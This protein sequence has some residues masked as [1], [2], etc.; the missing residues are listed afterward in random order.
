MASGGIEPL[1]WKIGMHGMNN[2]EYSV[3][4][5]YFL[6]TLRGTLVCHVTKARIFF[7]RIGLE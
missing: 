6:S 5:K 3:S 7:L 4:M 1:T 2:E